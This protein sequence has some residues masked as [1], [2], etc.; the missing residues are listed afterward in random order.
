[1]KKTLKSDFKYLRFFMLTVLKTEVKQP[2][3]PMRY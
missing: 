2:E 1:M 3:T